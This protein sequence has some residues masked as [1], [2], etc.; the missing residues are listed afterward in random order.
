MYSFNSRVRFSEVDKN[1]QLDFASV[2]N[3][4]QDCSTFHSEDIGNGFEY[5][6]SINRVWVLN[7]WQIIVNRFPCIGENIVIGTWPYDFKNMYGY[8][9]FVIKDESNQICAMANS[10]WVYVDSVSM[11]PAKLTSDLLKTYQL[12][13]KLEMDYLPRKISLPTDFET[14]SSFCVIKS[15]IDTN[16]HVNNGQYIKMAEE[17]LPSNFKTKQ[18]R[19]EYRKSAVLGDIIVPKIHIS[20]N[21]CLIILAN[22]DDL[23]YAIVEFT[24]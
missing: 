20:E 11:R 13:D 8:R 22:T 17:F 1:K 10:I 6:E 16:N 14:L 2:I 15:N 3:Y 19:A 5:L 18:M 4:F 21:A 9:N 23:P 12:E 7:S 24:K